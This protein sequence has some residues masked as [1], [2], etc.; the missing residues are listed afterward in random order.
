MVVLVMAMS[1]EVSV[2]GP[3]GTVGAGSWVVDGARTVG[4]VG[5]GPVL[6]GVGATATV[7]TG[8]AVVVG[9]AVLDV[10]ARGGAV[11]V[12]AAAAAVVGV[13]PFGSVSVAEGSLGVHPEVAVTV[14][15]AGGLV[16]SVV[17][18]AVVVDGRSNDA[19]SSGIEMVVGAPAID[20]S[21]ATCWLRALTAW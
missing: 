5:P 7:V 19:V 16:A 1:T 6:G 21:S 11:V 4:G 3:S 10:A 15:P 18:G 8:E 17:R 20:P 14:G 12:D 9:P 2:V 13:V